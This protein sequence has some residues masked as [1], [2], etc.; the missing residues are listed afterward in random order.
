[1]SEH[2]STSQE[3]QSSPEVTVVY[4]QVDH[5]T[6]QRGVKTTFHE[7][8]SSSRVR[9]FREE[10]LL[11]EDVLALSEVAEPPCVMLV[12]TPD[13]ERMCG[14]HLV[15]ADTVERKKTSDKRK[16]PEP[17]PVSY[18]L[19]SYDTAVEYRELDPKTLTL[20][21]GEVT[22]YG[23]I[24]HSVVETDGRA[25]SASDRKHRRRGS[26]E[27]FST[28]VYSSLLR[29]SDSGVH[30]LKLG[31]QGIYYEDF[32]PKLIK[33]HFCKNDQYSSFA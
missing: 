9:K 11:E 30:K 3:R 27:S 28:S 17:E 32:L 4:A 25:S 13:Q 23:T 12:Q 10:P 6:T 16:S 8:G 33:E 19:T 2:Q 7:T 29:T 5:K 18:R 31:E 22:P 21:Y 24:A 20:H 14:Q 15:V 26:S 1:M